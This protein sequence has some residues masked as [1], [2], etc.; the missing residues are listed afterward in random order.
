MLADATTFRMHVGSLRRTAESAA[1]A[2]QDEAAIQQDCVAPRHGK[3]GRSRQLAAAL[4]SDSW[5]V[6][7]RRDRVDG[8]G[9]RF[10]RPL[11]CIM[12]TYAD[13]VKEETVRRARGA[14][15]PASRPALPAIT[16][17]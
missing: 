4:A 7:N 6:A 5:M 9:F 11:E 16:F 17:A 8:R 1:Q 2:L 15:H 13:P 14:H 12:G 3:K 10:R